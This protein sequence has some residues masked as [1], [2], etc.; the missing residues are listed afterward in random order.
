MTGISG[1]IAGRGRLGVVVTV[2]LV[3]LA[4]GCAWAQPRF[5]PE[6]TGFNPLEDQIGV[7]N[8]AQLGLQWQADLGA[9][10]GDVVV[11]D[12]LVIVAVRGASFTEGAGVVT[13]LDEATGDEVWSVAVPPGTCDDTCFGA[14]TTIASADGLVFVATEAS[15]RFGTLVALDVHTGDLVRTYATAATAQPAVTGGRLY[16]VTQAPEG[17]VVQAW[18]VATGTSEWRSEPGTFQ[19]QFSPVAVAGGRVYEARQGLQAYDAAGVAGCSG[20]PTVCRP[21]WGALP[22]GPPAVSGDF[23]AVGSTVFAAGGCG[24]PLCTALW[25]GQGGGPAIADGVLYGTN[26][27]T[28]HLEAY[29]LAG[30]G[31]PECAPL[32]EASAARFGVTTVANGVVYVVDGNDLMT[33]AAAGCGATL[34]QQLANLDMPATVAFAAEPVVVNGRVFVALDDGTLAAFG[35]P[36]P[37]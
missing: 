8:V 1:W 30:C 18:D 21:L 5:G 9:N 13:A 11:T 19:P 29:A 25:Q 16:A 28:A 7:E 36:A 24:A 15:G 34:C 31:A 37:A 4:G 32:W 10:G 12:G 3:L 14:D 35:L 26:S 6:R 33:Y 22:G 27:S 20:T 23:V 17:I 2:A